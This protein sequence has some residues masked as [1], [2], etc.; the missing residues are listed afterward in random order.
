MI[1]E[2]LAYDVLRQYMFAPKS[3]FAKVFI[4]NQYYGLMNNTESIDKG[5]ILRNFLSSAYSF[6]KC[7]P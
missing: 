2:P 3:N 5:F 6:V 4:N 1:R 7:N